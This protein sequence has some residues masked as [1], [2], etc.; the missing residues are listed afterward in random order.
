MTAEYG[1]IERTT[2][3]Y[4]VDHYVTLE[5]GGSND[6][7]NLW[8]EAAEP[9]PGFHEKDQVENYLHEQVCTGRMNLLDAQRASATDWLQVYQR[10]RE[11][12]APV[13]APTTASV[14]LRSWHPRVVASRSRRCLALHLA[15]ARVS[16]HR[17]QPELRVRLRIKHRRG[18]PLPLR[19]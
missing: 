13:V 5:D 4:E 2:G 11:L 6:I 15:A 1:I 3:E 9:R 14:C 8:P 10:L 19:D 7:A 17:R 12:E 16:P 18:R